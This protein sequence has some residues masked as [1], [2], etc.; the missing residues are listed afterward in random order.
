MIVHQC[1][2]PAQ[3]A[4]KAVSMNAMK[5]SRRQ[6]LAMLPAAAVPGA[7]AQTHTGV[8]VGFT[9]DTGPARTECGVG[10]LMPW[11]DALW[12]VT[13]NSHKKA[14]GTGLALYRIGDSLKPERIHV[15]DGTHANR[16]I[17]RE[18]QP[19]H[20]RALRHRYAGQGPGDGAVPGS[21]PHRHHDPPHRSGEPRLHAHH[22]GPALRSRCGLPSIPAGGG[23]GERNRHQGRAPLQ[24]RVHRAGPRGGGQQRLLQ[25]RRK[26]GGP[27]RVGRQVVLAHPQPQAAHGMRRPA[28]HGQRHL[29]HRAGTSPPCCSGR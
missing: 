22:G 18:S 17:H 10:A 19:G 9:A 5:L 24:G 8:N 20:H 25:L 2:F 7:L 27:V 13:Y 26:R 11:A 3:G 29:L 23:P 4:A 12:A 6:M 14:T 21:P 28:Q 15:H 16:L 1:A